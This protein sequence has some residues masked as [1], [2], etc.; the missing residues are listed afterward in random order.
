MSE[1]D[2]FCI[3]TEELYIK[4]HEFR[5]PCCDPDVVPQ[6]RSCLNQTNVLYVSDVKT[7]DATQDDEEQFLPFQLNYEFIC[8][9]CNYTGEH[10]TS[11]QESFRLVK[12]SWVQ[13][14]PTQSSS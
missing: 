4:N 8:K 5:S 11:W 14:V 10:K 13:Q 9:C 2:E 1:N 7:F 12:S 6:V 3:E